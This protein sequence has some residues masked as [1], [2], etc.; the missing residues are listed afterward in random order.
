MMKLT[1]LFCQQVLALFPKKEIV[2]I[3]DIGN[4]ENIIS[5][6]VDGGPKSL[7]VNIMYDNILY[8]S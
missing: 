6:I 5:G 4:V 2:K 3:R 8:L 1:S 7:Q